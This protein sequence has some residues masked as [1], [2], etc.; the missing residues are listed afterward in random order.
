[1]SIFAGEPMELLVKRRSRLALR[2]DE[3]YSGRA[4]RHAGRH[5]RGV[6]T[7]CGIVIQAWPPSD[8]V[9]EQRC[10]SCVNDRRVLDGIFCVLRSRAI[11]AA[12]QRMSFVGPTPT[13]TAVQQ[14]VGYL[15]Y[16]GRDGDVVMTAA[17]DPYQNSA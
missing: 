9:A 4:N 13:T 11:I 8:D 5:A 12:K 14:V 1:M 17:F 7:G 16:S 3:G 15:G 2:S 6:E 10:M